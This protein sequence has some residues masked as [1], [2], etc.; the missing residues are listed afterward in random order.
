MCT[1]EERK[2][3]AG[4]R[5]DKKENIYRTC[6]VLSGKQASCEGCPWQ[7][8]RCFDCRG[9]TDWL[10]KQ[11]GLDLYGDTCGAQYEK[12]SNW[13]VRGNYADMPAGLVG[14]VFERKNGIW[15]HTG[16]HVGMGVTVHCSGTVQSGER[17]WT[18][19]GIP[20]GLYSDAELKA[21]GIDPKNNLPTLRR[22]SKGELV[23]S[24]QEY[25]N[26]EAGAGLVIDGAFGAKTEE[27]VKAFQKT[28]GL[29]ADGVVGPKTWA[30]MGGAPE[31]DDFPDEP[32]EAPEEGTVR[33][34]VAM[35]LAWVDT[36]GDMALDVRG[37][38]G[39]D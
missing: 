14:C 19:Y 13:A 7:G 29:T 8:T 35:L 34:P 25:L 36:L 3:R 27:A 37:Y 4:Y 23:K 20:A 39:G 22:G 6:P 12:E 26:D 32:G 30:A 18:A 17:D 5:P 16:M 2:T 1:P 15:Q 10:L 38:A 11:V 31:N 21:A 28:K 33:V 9:F 24:L